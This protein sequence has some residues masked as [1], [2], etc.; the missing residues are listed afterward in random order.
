MEPIKSTTEAEAVARIIE[1]REILAYSEVSTGK[2]SR[3]ILV[4]QDKSVLDLEQFD[5]TPRRKRA[6]PEF[7]DPES[8]IRYFNAHAVK[9]ESIIFG[10]A[11]MEGGSFNAVIDYHTD[12]ADHSA[13]NWRSHRATLTLRATPEWK[14][15][16]GNDRKLL[17]QNSFAEFIEENL[18]DIVKPD[19]AAVLDV[20]QDIQGKKSCNFRSSQRLSDGQIKV[21]YDEQIEVTGPNPTRKSG[22]MKVPQ[23]LIIRLSPFVG[24]PAVDIKLR[25]RIR[26]DGSNGI[27]FQY[28]VS[29]PHSV[30]EDAFTVIREQIAKG[31]KVHPM[32]GV[33]R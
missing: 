5:N 11:T 7:F 32:L 24:S 26:I 1:A 15:W 12:C 4:F 6:H 17:P 18:I 27:Q 33:S 14:R 30:V 10:D 2:D 16:I 28:I 8:F 25:L 31:T 3:R 20:V 21:V 22:E 19:A 23:E 13:A 29:K 9:Q